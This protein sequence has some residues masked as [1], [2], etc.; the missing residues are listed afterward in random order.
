MAGPIKMKGKGMAINAKQTFS[1]L[2][3]ELFANNK[4]MLVLVAVCLLLCSVAT[5]GASIYII[6]MTQ[7]LFESGLIKDE[8]MKSLTIGVSVMAC[9]YIVGIIASYFKEWAMAI[10]T[11]RFLNDI[12]KKMFNGMQNLPIK[13]FDTHVHGD[14]MSYYTND[15]DAIRQLVSQSLPSIFQASIML[16][17][18]FIVM[19]YYSLWLTLIVLSCVVIMFFVSKIVGGNSAKYFIR[20]QKT[21]AKTEGYIEEMIHG[22]KVIKVFCHEEKAKEGF[23]KVNDELCHDAAQ[24][25]TYAN[26]LMPIL[27]NIGNMMYVLLAFTGALIVAKEG[28]NV[29]LSGVSRDAA[30]IIP[31][32]VGFLTMGKQFTNQIAQISQQINA[33]VMALAGAERVFSLMDE[34]PEEDQGYVTLVYAKRD[35]NGNLIESQERTGLWA[36]K[37]PH[38]ADGTVTYVPLRGDIE[39]HEVDFG[40]VPEKIVLHDVSLH[41]KPGE[42]YAFV[43]A[44]GAG[45]TTITN[46]LNR[47]YD[48]DDGKIRYDGININKIKKSD[49]RRSLGMV[50][51]DTSLFTGTIMENIRYG[52][53]DAT[54]E[55]VYAAARI[56][57]ADDFIT[58][59][60]D[61]YNTMLTNDGANLS[62]G[63]R[64]LLS[65]ARAAVADAPVMI[66]DEATSSIDTRTEL[67]VQRGTDRLMQGRTVFIIAHRLSTVQ[68]ADTIMVLEHGRVIERG[69]HEELLALKGQYYQLYT[70]AFELE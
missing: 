14:I 3:K 23:D 50:L 49:L 16:I 56:A 45:K 68:N 58:R 15:V 13:Y 24:A 8:I 29:G 43:G 44:T 55:E 37:H 65:I 42:K 11:Q 61:G 46:L 64:Q 30:V 18:V 1:R 6:N 47:F 17:I 9:I 48:I 70:G 57:N 39:M 4:G 28:L 22:Q 10:V 12:R 19:I 38:K 53:L 20:Q 51:Q 27:G 36:W 25:N 7:S 67:L 52:R 32:V 33:V 63:Q 62:Q 66:M 59:L 21:I 31:L 40:Y 60:P 5:S 69:S 41:A 26:V 35:E 54:D 2:M 34:K